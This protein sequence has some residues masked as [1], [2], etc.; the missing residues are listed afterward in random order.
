MDWFVI[1][2]SGEYSWDV[3]N[4]WGGSFVFW[5]QCLAECSQCC[6]SFWFLTFFLILEGFKG[7]EAWYWQSY[8]PISLP[9]GEAFFPAA[10]VVQGKG[11]GEDKRSRCIYK[12]INT[13]R[14]SW[15]SMGKVYPFPNL[16]LLPSSTPKIVQLCLLLTCVQEFWAKLLG[17]RAQCWLIIH[18]E[19]LLVML[20]TLLRWKLMLLRGVPLKLCDL[21]LSRCNGYFGDQLTSG[22]SG[23]AEVFWFCQAFTCRWQLTLERC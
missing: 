10:G 23:T 12:T 17:L 2:L 22:D 19:S 11:F 13:Y 3:K 15:S 18:L 4:A 16:Q 5:D 21:L 20:G 7:R 6:M 1:A 14:K 8:N 9:H